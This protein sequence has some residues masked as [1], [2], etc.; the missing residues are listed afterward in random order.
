[1]TSEKVDLLN[2]KNAGALLLNAMVMVIPD[3]YD[4]KKIFNIPDKSSEVE[5]ELF[6]NGMSV[7]YMAAVKEAWDVIQSGLN[8]SILEEAEKLVS[9]AGLDKVRYAI[10]DAN[11]KITEA[12]GEALKNKV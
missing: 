9:E 11:W 10:Q 7:P 5:V 8:K 12:L 3:K 2:K 1:M 6:I 4:I